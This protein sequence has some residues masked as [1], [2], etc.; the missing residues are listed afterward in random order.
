[1][2][3]PEADEPEFLHLT[4]IGRRSG[5]PRDIEI[6]F[7]RRGGRYYV[8]AETG[9]RAQWVRNL[10]ADSRVRWRVADATFTGR[11]RIVDQ[12]RE[13]SRA[14]QTLSRRKYGW[15]DGLVVELT[16]G[17]PLPRRGA[18]VLTPER[19]SLHRRGQAER[20]RRASITRG[21]REP[22]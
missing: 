16:P 15:G 11:A 21:R 17:A 10:L 12:A 3:A 22:R 2:S 20:T 5:Q 19:L 13:L 4:T 18:G 14:V 1:M 6:W 8:I 9:T 7:T